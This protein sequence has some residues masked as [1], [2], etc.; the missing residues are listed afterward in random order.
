MQSR[1]A[2]RL[3]RSVHHLSPDVAGLAMII[4]EDKIEL[5]LAVVRLRYHFADVDSSDLSRITI[6]SDITAIMK[7]RQR[8]IAALEWPVAQVRHTQL[9]TALLGKSSRITSSSD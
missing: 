8:R 5:W 3:Y 4:M 7:T 1:R 9:G 2:D 6:R